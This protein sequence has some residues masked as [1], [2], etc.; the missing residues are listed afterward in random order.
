MAS[1]GQKRGLWHFLILTLNVRA[2][3]RKGLAKTLALRRSS[4]R[5]VTIFLKIRNDNWPPLLIEPEK[6]SRRR[7]ALPQVSSISS[8]LQTRITGHLEEVGTGCTG[9]VLHVQPGCSF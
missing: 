2:V 7:Q 5:S 9:S 1:P 4:V 8:C 3:M 6:N